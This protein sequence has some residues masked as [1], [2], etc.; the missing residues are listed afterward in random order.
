[1]GSVANQSTANLGYMPHSRAYL[2][3][4]TSPQKPYGPSF[5]NVMNRMWR[6]SGRKYVIYAVICLGTAILFFVGGA[7]YF[8]HRNVSR[9]IVLNTEV[10]GALMIAAGILFTGAFFHF[11]YQA[12]VASNRWRQNIRVSDILHVFS[13]YLIGFDLIQTIPIFSI[14]FLPS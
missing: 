4:K 6:G 1:M 8:G 10:L 12:N 3:L 7:L 13:S 11:M 2:P 9:M 14:S 5:V